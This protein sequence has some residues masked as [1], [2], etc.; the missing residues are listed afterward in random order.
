M[1]ATT[2]ATTTGPKLSIAIE[3]STISVTK[4]APAIGALYAEVMPAAAPQATSRRSRG[5]SKCTQ[6]PISEA[7][8]AASCTIGPSRPIEP[9]LAIVNSEE[10]LRHRLSLTG[11][12]PSPI[13]TASM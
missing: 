12:T 2:A 10:T 11:T 5:G 7:A 6:R 4:N 13:A 8:S 3:P 1:L 9:P